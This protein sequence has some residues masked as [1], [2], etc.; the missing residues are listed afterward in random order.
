MKNMILTLIMLFFVTGCNDNQLVLEDTGFYGTWQEFE[1]YSAL[2]P[3][4]GWYRIPNENRK[5]DE[6]FPDGTFKSTRFCECNN[7]KK[8]Y[9]GNVKYDNT[10]ITFEYRCDE[11]TADTE[12]SPGIFSYDYFFEDYKTVVLIPNYLFCDEGCDIRYVKTAD[13]KPE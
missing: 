3:G 6:I 10:Q 1:S 5:T 13:P 4:D 12:P 2:N 7:G 8:T 11:F 9:I